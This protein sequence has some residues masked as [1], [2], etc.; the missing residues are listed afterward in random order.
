[1]ILVIKTP[2]SV[3]KKD[4]KETEQKKKYFH[5]CICYENELVY[6]VHNSNKELYGFITN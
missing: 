5:Y 1:M 6:P 2:V 3:F 4:Y